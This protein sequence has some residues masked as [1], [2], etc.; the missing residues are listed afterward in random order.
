MKVQKTRSDFWGHMTLVHQSWCVCV[1]V[2]P[3]SHYN[4]KIESIDL[5]DLEFV[6]LKTWIVIMVVKKNIYLF[7]YLCE[8]KSSVAHIWV[9]KIIIK[10]YI[11]IW[12]FTNGKKKKKQILETINRNILQE[13]KVLQKKKKLQTWSWWEGEK[14]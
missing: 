8:W 14:V 4:T 9:E 6:T 12:E 1:C 11:R 7:I 5:C 2:F 3:F 10:K 13:W